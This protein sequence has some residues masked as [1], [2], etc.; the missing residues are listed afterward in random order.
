MLHF[1]LIKLKKTRDIQ[2]E[3]A[4]ET[5]AG[6]KFRSGIVWGLQKREF[7]ERVVWNQ[8]LK[9]INTWELIRGGKETKEAWGGGAN[10]VWG[11]SRRSEG[12]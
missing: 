1:E 7:K 6:D 10:K 4:K 12:E 3:Y 11:K 5:L 2:V 9:S 8:A